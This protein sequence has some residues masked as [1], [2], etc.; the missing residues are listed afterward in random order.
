MTSTSPI[1]RQSSRFFFEHRGVGLGSFARFESALFRNLQKLR[2]TLS[3]NGGW[4]ESLSPGDVWV[5][6]KQF[7]R[8][9]ESASVDPRHSI[10]RVGVSRV[11][12]VEDDL[13]VHLRFSPTPEIAIVEVLY[14][15]TFGPALEHVL[16]KESL[17]YRLN[18][19]DGSIRKTSRWLFSFWPIQY[20]AFRTVPLRVAQRELRQGGSVAIVSTDFSGFYDSIEPEFLLRKEF[21]VEVT[22]K[23]GRLD[24]RGYRRATKSLLGMYRRFRQEAGKRLGM[25]VGIGV[26]VG[27]LTSR[28]VANLALGQFDDAVVEQPGIVCYR[29]YVDDLVIVARVGQGEDVSFDGA[30][31]RF[32]PTL[33]PTKDGYEINA[34]AVGR[35][36]SML[37]LQ[38][39]KTRVHHLKGIEGQEFLTAIR[40]DFERFVSDRRAFMDSSASIE[41]ALSKLVLARKG[42]S[43][44]RVLRDADRV[45][46]EHFGVSNTLRSLERISSLIDPAEARA[47]TSR[48]IVQIQRVLQGDGDWLDTLPIQFR[49]LTVAVG[50]GEW[51]EARQLIAWMNKRWGNVLRLRGATGDLFYRNIKARK[52]TALV[53]MRN[54]LHERRVEAVIGALQLDQQ[55]A[56]E[57]AFRDG[58]RYRTRRISFGRLATRA[59][60]FMA[61]D[62]RLRDR[63]DDRIGIP[64]G[65][66]RP[67]QWSRE[68]EL[69]SLSGRFDAIRQF[70]VVCK[71][72]GDL[73]WALPAAQL[74]ASTR[75]PSYFDMSRRWLYRTDRKG[76][77]PSHF[78]ELL[79]IVNAVRGTNYWDPVGAIQDQ[80]TASVPRP[81]ELSSGT[82]NPQVVLGDLP[83]EDSYWSGAAR[84]IPGQRHGAPVLSL[85]RL[86]SLINV[87]AQTDKLAR[88]LNENK[89]KRPTLLVLPELAIPRDWFRALARHAIDGCKFGVIT[90]LEYLHDPVNPFVINQVFAVLPG[91]YGVAATLVWTKIRPAREEAAQLD[92]C[93][94]PTS[95]RSS[96]SK[97]TWPC[98]EFAKIVDPKL[99]VPGKSRSQLLKHSGGARRV[100]IITTAVTKHALPTAWGTR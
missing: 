70:T 44:L 11:D 67:G 34:E 64:Q 59:R 43:P 81:I 63:E 39:T 49:L 56:F 90:G 40:S 42:E 84:R 100:T 8:R 69:E 73:I 19:Q 93:T 83:L 54:Y 98:A 97:G 76:F 2:E 4:F 52:R 95:L 45:K 46:L 13:D 31:Q 60:R 41:D 33:D 57:G 27:A 50:S 99:A 74:F 16:R 5:V 24:P 48:T 18:V 77:R 36:G 14:L 51:R 53:S 28:L 88:Q 15:W 66:A 22:E 17:G 94:P 47:F 65:Q 68:T 92:E 9:M 55:A 61:A 71:K 21:M 6:P 91:P 37:C 85:N 72:L 26:P 78:E 75:P 25:R 96:S 32:V 12:A 82:V 89:R 79:H 23:G 87:L 30:L 7:R 62:L 3:A 80:F 20:Q 58:I 35:A 38:H 10:T 29:R 86:D 1:D